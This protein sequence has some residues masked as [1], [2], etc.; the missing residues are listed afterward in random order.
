MGG[1]A[2]L[3]NVPKT[4][5]VSGFDKVA[6]VNRPQILARPSDCLKTLISC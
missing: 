2:K 3:D 5:N 6:V 1:D 4:V